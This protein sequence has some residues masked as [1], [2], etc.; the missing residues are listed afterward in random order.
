MPQAVH[1]TSRKNLSQVQS[2]MDRAFFDDPT[3]RWYHSDS[4]DT[5]ALEHHQY[6]GGYL[7][8]YRD[9]FL[10]T[11]KGCDFDFLT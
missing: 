3:V 10:S 1:V 4:P 7:K 5:F 11:I 8:L 2:V 6:P 9:A